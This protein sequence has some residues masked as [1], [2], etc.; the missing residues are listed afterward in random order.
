MKTRDEFIKSVRKKSEIAI[1]EKEAAWADKKIKKK[2]IISWSATAAA[3]LVIAVGAG[4]IG[5]IGSIVNKG[6]DGADTAGTSDGAAMESS[7]GTAELGGQTMPQEPAK[8]IYDDAVT[9]AEG[10][11]ME[12]PYGTAGKHLY[13]L[14]AGIVLEDL[15]TGDGLGITGDNIAIY[16]DWFYNLPDE[17]KLTAE[18]YEEECN[19][20]EPESTVRYRFTMD[21]SQGEDKEGVD[22]TFYI[23][24]GVEMP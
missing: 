21:F 13:M 20:A 15:E 24:D 10:T 18:E 14:P 6:T 2:R 23:V 17:M 11:D 9:D 12:K 4:S 16:M 1:A 3:C 5:T 19:R 8:G 22:R 7:T